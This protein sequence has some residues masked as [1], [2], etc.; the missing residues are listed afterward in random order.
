MSIAD[1]LIKNLMGLGLSNYEARAFIAL[2][3]Y[4]ETTAPNIARRAKIPLSK[5]YSV[6]RSLEEKGLIE[7]QSKRPKV[8]RIVDPDY[9]LEN[10]LKKYE[11]RKNTIKELLRKVLSLEKYEK[12]GLWVVSGLD[13]IIRRVRD[14]MNKS[15][16]SLALATPDYLLKKFSSKLSALGRNGVNLSLVI[17]ETDSMKTKFYVNTLSKYARVKVRSIPAVSTLFIDR[18]VGVVFYLKTSN[19][20]P[21]LDESYA[22]IV[23]D[24][25]LLRMIN[26]FFHLALW[27]T[28][29]DVG[30][31]LNLFSKP[32]SYTHFWRLVEDVDILFKNN[33]GPVYV[34]IEG[35]Y[36]KSKEPAYIKGEV[37]DYSIGENWLSYSIVVKSNEGKV[38]VGGWGC[39]L[40]DVEAKKV[41]LYSSFCEKIFSSK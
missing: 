40:E 9:S 12:G 35:S 23:E 33:L 16:I 2:A 30:P 1:E 38:T 29:T 36:V 26:D 39:F 8:Y 17:Y 41:I 7:S 14:L 27:L 15:A 20:M 19:E 31:N 4:R 6:L 28:S 34:E 13:N 3:L 11:E 32:L 22:M 24:E 18:E 21:Y 25:N 5:I 37:I 10:L